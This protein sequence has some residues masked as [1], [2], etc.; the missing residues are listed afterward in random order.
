M[1]LSLPSGPL[2]GRNSRGFGID[3][4]GHA[5]PVIVRNIGMAGFLHC[6]RLDTAQPI[7]LHRTQFTMS[8]TIPSIFRQSAFN[9]MAPFWVRALTDHPFAIVIQDERWAPETLVR[10]L[11]EARQAK[12]KYGWTHPDIDEKRW[13]ELSEKI[14]PRIQDDGKQTVVILGPQEAKDYRAFTSS[15]TNQG[16]VFVTF[17][18][19]DTLED[20]CSCVTRRIFTPLPNFVIYGITDNQVVDLEAR[21]DIGFVK[22][23]DGHSWWITA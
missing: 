7:S 18:E 4:D 21:Y 19:Q 8:Q 13:I 22:R 5:F 16:E 6:R 14:F 3:G 12:A 1:T 23:A 2:P 9:T 20:F 15:V 10:K 17:V 11:R